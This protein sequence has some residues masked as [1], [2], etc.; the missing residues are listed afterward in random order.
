MDRTNFTKCGLA[1]LTAIFL[2]QPIAIANSVFE[3]EEEKQSFFKG[4]VAACAE[5]P[6]DLD[7]C[8]SRCQCS[9]DNA[10]NF[11]TRNEVLQLGLDSR[12]EEI[13]AKAAKLSDF[14]S[15]DAQ[16]IPPLIF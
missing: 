1:V 14:C 7:I 6:D 3:D 9:M 12:P 5:N 2:I 10:S 8:K 13:N 4:C 16:P 15:A 11:L